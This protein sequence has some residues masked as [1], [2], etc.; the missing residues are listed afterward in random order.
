[1]NAMADNNNKQLPGELEIAA[2]AHALQYQYLELRY[3][4]RTEFKIKVC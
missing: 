1:M 2:A 4:E 3:A